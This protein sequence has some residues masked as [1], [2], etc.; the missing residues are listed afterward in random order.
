MPR[1]T[2]YGFWKSPIT[3]D[4]VAGH[5]LRLG[6]IFLTSEDVYWSE[7]RPAENGRNV[8]VRMRPNHTFED[9]QPEPFNARTRVHE[10]GGAAFVIDHRDVY[11]SND[12]DQRIYHTSPS[13]NPCAITP[14]GPWR[15]ADAAIDHHR[16]RLI[17]VREDHSESLPECVNSLVAIDTSNHC[18]PQVLVEGSD[19][20]SNPTINAEGT[21]LAW[22]SWNHPN[23]PWDGTE[24]WLAELDEKGFPYNSR[25]IAGGLEES[26]FQPQWLSTGDLC[27]VSDSTGWW[28]LY[29]YD[30]SRVVPMLPMEAEFGSPQ[31]VFGQSTYALA[32]KDTL[33]FTCARSGVWRLGTIDL[34]NGLVDWIDTPYTEISQLRAAN[35]K[36]VF[37]G[38]SPVEPSSIV[39]LDV[40]T[41]DSCVLRRAFDLESTMD[42]YFSPARPIE[43]PTTDGRSAHAFF[44]EPHNP[45][46]EGFEDEKPPLIVK[47]HGGPT[48]ATSSELSLEIQYWTSRG[49]ALVD[50]NFGGSTGFG[51]AYRER[52][53]GQWGV[54]DVDDTV[55]AAQ[56]CVERDWC[57]K[58]RLIVK[59]GSAGGYTTLAALTFRDVFRAGA[60]YYGIGDL[61][62]LAKYTHKFESRYL[63]KLIGS[64]EANRSRYIERSPVNFIEELSAPVIFFQGSEDKVVPLQQAETMVAALRMKGV[65]TTYVLFD[66]E[67]HGFRRSETIRRCLDYEL[68]F[69]S[70]MI[71]NK[72]L[73]F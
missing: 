30:L 58:Q 1:Q 7:G 23:M 63:E 26:I 5:T 44:Y 47:T 53:T 39:M 42:K 24:L 43:F 28:N 22:L 11:F 64:Y 69:Y 14:E 38:A 8:I 56:Y 34:Q 50:V 46:F 40:E 66:G 17:C 52:L 70:I 32:T 35:S 61:E 16:K 54:V 27:Y 72:G 68:C 15:Y 33:V 31:W 73:S 10:Y 29:R 9:I 36:I 71:L 49:F 13:D 48:G 51:R 55:N 25:C 60:S 41:K 3:S 19:F 12:A 4:L 21:Q 59:G 67:Q 65:P 45:D 20:Y 2:Q 6:Q 18:K 37:R 62:S 57:D